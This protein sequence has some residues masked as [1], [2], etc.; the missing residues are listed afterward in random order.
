MKNSKIG[1]VYLVGAGPGDPDLI[2]VRGRRLLA[3]ADAVVYDNLVPLE[4]VV[5]MPET[6]E[7]H[8]VGKQ[9][10]LHALPQE[11]INKLLVALAREGKAVVRLKGG[12]PCMFGRGGEEASELH[13]AG[14]P[15]KLFRV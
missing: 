12:D 6:I 14:V 3:E 4:L 11:D 2:T 7:R 13:E 8:Y 15:T 5:T 1:T 9:S 10:S